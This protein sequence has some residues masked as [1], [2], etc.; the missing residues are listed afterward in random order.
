MWSGLLSRDFQRIRSIEWMIAVSSRSR[1]LLRELLSRD[2]YDM[3]IR[4]VSDLGVYIDGIR[5][6]DRSWSP[7]CDEHGTTLFQKAR[8]SG[9]TDGLLGFSSSTVTARYGSV[10]YTYDEKGMTIY[11]K[12]A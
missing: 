11:A 10:I 4:E 7:P 3:V 12:A 8:G 2:V 5:D 6:A 9:A 1:D